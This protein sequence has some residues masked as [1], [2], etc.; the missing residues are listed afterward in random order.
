MTE[1]TIGI[2]GGGR[3]TRILLEGW[4]RAGKSLQSITV[5]DS[6]AE[7][8]AWLK[9]RFPKVATTPVNAHSAGRQ[10][11]LLAVHPPAVAAVLEEVK[12]ALVK[13]VLEMYRT[14][15]PAIYEKIKP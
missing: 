11:V 10:I 2:I 5:S 9:A 15:L 1:N 14:R 8:L 12:A 7:S 6:S 4:A 3:I 13:D